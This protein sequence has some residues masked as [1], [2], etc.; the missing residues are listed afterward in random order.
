MGYTINDPALANELLDRGVD[1]II[2]NN[3]S[4]HQEDDRTEA[5]QGS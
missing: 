1:G 5:A 4:L 2:T 3:T